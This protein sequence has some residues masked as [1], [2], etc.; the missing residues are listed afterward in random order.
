MTLADIVK[1][2]GGEVAAVLDDANIGEIAELMIQDRIGSVVVRTR[3]GSILGIVNERALVE[4]I[5]ISGAD[6]AEVGAT[7]VMLA[8]VP[9]ANARTSIIEGFQTM[10]ERRFRHLLV[11]DESRAI[12]VVSIGDLVK[13]YIHDMEL[14]NAVL[15]D[16]T[17][18]SL[19]AGDRTTISTS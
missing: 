7:D 14:E 8:P 4:A 5:A 3:A 16:M 13:W 1:Q 12:G 18:A 2:K 15:R 17:A 6:L 10:T 19:V 9:S 11:T